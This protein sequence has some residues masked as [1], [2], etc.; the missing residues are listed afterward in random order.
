MPLPMMTDT[1]HIFG[2]LL[3]T[4]LF[5]VISFL[6]VPLLASFLMRSF[7]ILGGLYLL[8]PSGGVSPFEWGPL[9][10]SD[11]MTNMARIFSGD[12]QNLSDVFRSFLFFIL[13]SIMSFLLFY[14]TIYLRKIFFFLFFTVVYVTV[15]DTFTLYDATFAIVRIFIIGFLLV[16]LLT[17]YR[18][19]ESYHFSKVPRYL[20]ARIS[21]VI[22]GALLIIGV[23]GLGAPKPGPQWEDPV[24]FIQAAVTGEELQAG[25]QRIGYGDNDEQLGGGFVHD[26]TPVFLASVERGMYW[27]GETK[28]FYSGSGWENNTPESLAESPNMVESDSTPAADRELKE[29]RVQMSGQTRFP[30]LFYPGELFSTTINENNVN[31]ISIDDFTAKAEIRSGDGPLSLEEYSFDYVE[32]SYNIEELRAI[33]GAD[34]AEIVE[35]Y[36]QLPDSLPE[37]VRDLAEE[38]TEEED[39]RY[40]Q[41]K[42][43][44]EHFAGAEFTYET[45]DVAVPEAGQDYVDQFLFETQSGYCDNFSTSMV[46]MLRSMDIPARWVKG[47]TS[48]T[49]VD[50]T[51]D[52]NVYSIDNSNAHSWVEVYFPGEGWV[53][54]EPTKGFNNTYEFEEDPDFEPDPLDTPDP[55]MDTE[56]EPEE[57]SAP[58]EEE[59]QE[60]QASPAFNQTDGTSYVG[61]WILVGTVIVT[62]GIIFF[63]RR[64]ILSSLM[65]LYYI[66]KHDDH[67]Y[68]RAYERLLWLLKLN[69][70]P[71]KST[72]T[73]GE[74]AGRIDSQLQ[75][76]DMMSLTKEYERT[77]YGGES[78]SKEAWNEHKRGWERIVRKIKP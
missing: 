73:L 59:E 55:D 16:G 29:A 13:L 27:R 76:N 78:V 31:S 66:K 51:D 18:T 60:E 69:G 34:P 14:W 44:E 58:E 48:G 25:V 32:A 36:T 75:A 20:A 39:N 47:F 43:I 23:A 45:E 68:E 71:R 2:F 70:Y 65:L 19:L 5:F 64:T 41:A 53:A 52:L 10:V 15:I 7:V 37:R 40:D 9:F 35:Y 57:P 38:V 1:G 11:V 8:F 28:D 74:Y 17:M 46:V 26:D 33:N 56:E 6:Q 21:L 77:L 49:L 72:E 42:A 62:A 50:S 30:H 24:P 4:A 63:F 67:E 12:W 22:A 61:V 3:A 54:F